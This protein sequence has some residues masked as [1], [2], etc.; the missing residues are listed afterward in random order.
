VGSYAENLGQVAKWMDKYPN[1][2]IDIAARLDQLGRQP[3]SAHDFITKYQDRVLFG[4]DYEGHF[5]D[6]RTRD[7]YHIHYRFLQTK[8]EYFEHPFPDMLGQWRI[9]GLGLDE[10]VLRKV[11]SENAKRIFRL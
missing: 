2:C 6:E 3:Y 4:T 9:F 5:D 10:E 1:M 11:Y 7:F 8:D